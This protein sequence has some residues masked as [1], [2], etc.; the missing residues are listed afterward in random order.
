MLQATHPPTVQD[1][2]ATVHQ[3]ALPATL[4]VHR[5]LQAVILVAV[6]AVTALLTMVGP[7]ILSGL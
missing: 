1:L 5:P 2:L 3:P 4:A 7:F 6:V